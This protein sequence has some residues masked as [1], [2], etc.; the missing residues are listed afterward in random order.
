MMIYEETDFKPLTKEYH[1]IMFNQ[2]AVVNS[3]LERIGAEERLEIEYKEYTESMFIIFKH[4]Y[5]R[6]KINLRMHEVVFNQMDTYHT[7]VVDAYLKGIL[8]ATILKKKPEAEP[9]P[10]NDEFVI[11]NTEWINNL[12]PDIKFHPIIAKLNALLRNYGNG[13]ESY[14]VYIAQRIKYTN[15]T[16]HT[17]YKITGNRVGSIK[18]FGITGE[19]PENEIEATLQMLLVKPDIMYKAIELEKWVE[20]NNNE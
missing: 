19:F 8:F 1:E 9:A 13:G 18:W 3:E 10:K 2:L 4:K 7:E 5:P 11:R 16:H 17:E 14:Q 6:F 20:A 12:H 15:K